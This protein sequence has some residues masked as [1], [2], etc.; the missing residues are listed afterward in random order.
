MV[1]VG[2]FLPS[3]SPSSA[4]AVTAVHD[5][6]KDG[7]CH[8]RVVEVGIPMFDRYLTG[9]PDGFVGGAI[10]EQFEHVAPFGLADGREVLIVEDQK[11]GL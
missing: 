7:V 8:R 11:V 1:G 10:V 9:D 5:A 6:V 4:R 2:A 3:D